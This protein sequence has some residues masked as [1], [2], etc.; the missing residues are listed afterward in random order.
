M[1]L[2]LPDT[3]QGSVLDLHAS[4]LY[5]ATSSSVA[6][7]VLLL[8]SSQIPREMFVIPHAVMAGG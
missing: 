3:Q 8:R 5:L 1:I 6:L 7:A 2:F 4:L